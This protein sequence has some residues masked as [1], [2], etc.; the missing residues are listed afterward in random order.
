MIR[1][2]ILRIGQTIAIDIARLGHARA[3]ALE[4]GQ[5]LQRP[6]ISLT[7]MVAAAVAGVAAAV[8]GEKSVGQHMVADGVG[9][10]QRRVMKAC[11]LMDTLGSP[12]IKSNRLTTWKWSDS[13]HL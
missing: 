9:K 12:S 7:E 8:G 10:L 6:I 1:G 11:S 13:R 5:G 4:I 3:R 2:S